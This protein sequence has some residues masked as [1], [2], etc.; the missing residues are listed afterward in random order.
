M[1]DVVIIK[2]SNHR[3]MADNTNAKKEGGINMLETNTKKKPSYRQNQKEAKF[4]GSL[5]PCCF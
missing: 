3:D 4:A 5:L 2:C 1:L